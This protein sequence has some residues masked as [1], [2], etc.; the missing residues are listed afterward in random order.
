[1]H[2]LLCVSTELFELLNK[3]VYSLLLLV[4]LLLV[5]RLG[6]GN[7]FLERQELDLS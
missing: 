2:L 1:M 6:P 5:G 3:A 7:S 4:L